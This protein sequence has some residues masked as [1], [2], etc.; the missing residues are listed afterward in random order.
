ML[1]F[2]CTQRGFS[3]IELLVAIAIVGILAAVA[4]PSYS[5]FIRRG[6]ADAAYGDLQAL[7]LAMEGRFRRVLSYPATPATNDT[8]AVKNL[9]TSWGPTTKAQAAFNFQ[10]TLV[11]QASGTYRVS[12]AGQTTSNFTNCTLILQVVRGAAT[13]FCNNPSACKIKC[14]APPAN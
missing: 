6:E 4:V 2:I 10:Y 9:V 7:S 3:L 5:S 11:D 1:K 14:D 12:A 13:R 8:A